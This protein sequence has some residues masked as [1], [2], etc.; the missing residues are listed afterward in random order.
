MTRTIHYPATVL[1]ASLLVAGCSS[2]VSGDKANDLAVSP[3]SAFVQ[4]SGTAPFT[5]VGAAVSG[6][7]TWSVEEGSPTGG[8]VSPTSGATTTYTAP[9]TT[10]TYH[11]RAT[12]T[13]NTGIFASAAVTV[14][15]VPP[16]GIIP[17]DRR[18]V[19]S[20]GIP[21]GTPESAGF[22]VHT[23]LSTVTAASINAAIQAAGAVATAAS[24]R[25]VQLP[26]GTYNINGMI[27]MD[28]PYVVLRGA[29]PMPGTTTGSGTRLV[30]TQA[31][32]D[33]FFMGAWATWGAAKN[34]TAVGGG[35]I[36][37]GSSSFTV[38]GGGVQAGDLLV[39]D[40]DDDGDVTLEGGDWYKRCGSNTDNGPAVPTPLSMNGGCRS[41]GQV[42]EVASVSGNDV[43]IVGIL[44]RGYPLSL[45]PQ[46]FGSSDARS[47]FGGIAIENMT[48]T[49]W[50]DAFGVYANWLKRSWIKN[51]EFDG[52]PSGQ[53]NFGHA[54][55]TTGVGTGT[56]GVDVRWF[57]SVRCA[58]EHNY[59][60]HSRVY[61]TN[62]EAYSI[63]LAEQTSDTLIQD[64][65]VWFK[66]KNVTLEA[67]GAGNVVA[68]N[69]LEDPVI[70]DSGSAVKIDWMEMC[71][72]GTHVATPSF[73][74]YEG[75]YV[76]KMGA[77]ETH[78]NATDLTFFR[79]YSK[80]NRL[81]TLVD[82]EGVAAVML[83]RY[84]NRMSFVG[85]VLT[86][87][88]A[89]SNA[90]YEAAISGTTNTTPGNTPKIWSIG[91]DGYN[92]NWDVYDPATMATLLRVGNYDYVR[93]RIDTAPTETVPDSLYLL[94]KPAFFGT[95]QW[96]WVDAAGTTKLYTLPAQ[97][98]WAA[99]T[100]MAP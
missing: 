52:W 5:A 33:M 62:N 32:T 68:Y 41:R 69:Y 31:N 35:N 76:S 34:V 66:N 38:A 40:M 22:T 59:L 7:V 27:T 83:N 14:T 78:G 17:A 71:L 3:S 1:A 75:N 63:S 67:S 54:P 93:N 21:G 36:P 29:G 81:Y 18:T 39:I 16:T 47:G 84:M 53:T 73:D 19:W 44:H 86:V 12:L 60:H 48:I 79:N 94:G 97:A 9:S 96:P 28:Q 6:G 50:G 42:V 98:R 13:S 85:N 11:V 72:D 61:V 99:G 87:R 30:M 8:T 24:P 51:V 2:E 58:M 88:G 37:K 74:L 90:V 43:T 95:H 64:N 4:P 56:Q 20:P 82:N 77:S 100:P 55:Y 26:S 46:V 91:L 49:G 89:G 45:R 57:R 23:T 65:I 25:V 92:G 15:T 80:G 10:G 70:A